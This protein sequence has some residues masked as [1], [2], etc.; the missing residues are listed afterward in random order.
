MLMV[1]VQRY[2]MKFTRTQLGTL[3]GYTASGG[4][5][6]AYF[7]ALKRHG[8]SRMRAARCRS[9]RPASTT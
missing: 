3:A 4:T 6:G 5:F 9:R 2:P 1:L 7:G 8:L